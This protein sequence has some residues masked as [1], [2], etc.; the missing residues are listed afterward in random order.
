MRTHAR[1]HRH[2]ASELRAPLRPLEQFTEPVHFEFP[3]AVAAEAARFAARRWEAQAAF[4]TQLQNSR[5]PLRT[6]DAPIAFWTHA[7]Q[8]YL[9]EAGRMFDTVTKAG[10]ANPS[11]G[12]DIADR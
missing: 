12:D 7:F 5:A 3:I 1:R 11:A 9:S 10:P 4:W 8:D 6:V 2:S